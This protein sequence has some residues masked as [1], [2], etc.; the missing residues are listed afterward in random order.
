[1]THHNQT[2]ELTTWF[3]IFFVELSGMPHNP[4]TKFVID[5]ALGTAPIAKRPYKMAVI[6]LAELK[7]A[8]QR[9]GAEGIRKA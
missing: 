5:L 4:D 8:T 7:E 1:M 9:A 2:K 6:E 3:L